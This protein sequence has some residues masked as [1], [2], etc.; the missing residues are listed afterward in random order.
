[1]YSTRAFRVF[2]GVFRGRVFLFAALL[3]LAL[4]AG[5]EVE[6]MMRATEAL[7]KEPATTFTAPEPG[8]SPP[9]KG[10]GAINREE[11][12]GSGEAAG[13]APA[14]PGAGGLQFKFQTPA[15]EEV[16]EKSPPATGEKEAQGGP[17]RKEG[18]VLTNADIRDILLRHHFYSTCG[19]YNFDFCNPDGNFNNLFQDNGDGTVTDRASRLVWEKGGSQERVTFLDALKYV[20]QLNKKKFAGSAD[21]RVPTIEELASLLESSWKNEDLFIERFFDTRQRGC[22]SSDTQGL[23]RAWKVDFH[24]GYVTDDPLSY[25]NWVRAVRS[26]E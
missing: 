14:G 25:L 21:W 11:K 19:N 16:P 1:M 26:E 20:Q 7:A 6:T 22:W 12:G 13:E 4:W 17:F 8:G 5:P 3:I 18:R 24:L 15:R 9:G 2:T 10:E 23:E